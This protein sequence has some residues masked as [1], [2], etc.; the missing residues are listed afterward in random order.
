MKLY[1]LLIILFVSCAN[2]E[3]KDLKSNALSG[4]L[5]IDLRQKKF[6]AQVCLKDIKTLNEKSL[7]LSSDFQV[8]Q[9]YNGSEI[10]KFK[11]TD[12]SAI[13]RYSFDFSKVTNE[14]CLSYKLKERVIDGNTKDFKGL[15]PLTNKLFRG[16]EQSAW[17]PYIF[18]K[19]QDITQDDFYNSGKLSYDLKVKCIDCNFI[20]LNGFSPI[21][22]NDAYFKSKKKYSP[23]I[24]VSRSKK[25]DVEGSFVGEQAPSHFQNYVE[26]LIKDISQK[27][28]EWSGYSVNI[29]PP[30]VLIFNSIQKKKGWAF[31]SYPTIAMT[32]FSAKNTYKQIEKTQKK[33]GERYL[34]HEVAHFFFGERLKPSGPEFW[35]LLES[36]SEYLGLRYL[37]EVNKQRYKEVIKYY[38]SRVKNKKMISLVANEKNSIDSFHRYTVGPLILLKLEKLMGQKYNKRLIKELLSSTSI[39]WTY[40]ELKELIISTGY[41]QE[42]FEAFEKHC[43]LVKPQSSCFEL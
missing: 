37:R 26:E 30:K 20:Y 16:T 42:K 6:D 32:H 2:L 28:R 39:Q 23:L 29:S 24:Y 41:S 36:F 34:A 19:N 22:G 18:K 4:I 21:K 7:Y 5:N 12:L 11:M 33:W 25:V 40:L 14:I 35:F 43:L 31:V 13:T 17:Y 3:R 10:I 9:I 1:L 38:V 27:Y 8:N 15:N